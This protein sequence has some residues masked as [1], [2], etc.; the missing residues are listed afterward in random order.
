MRRTWDR[1][2]ICFVRWP[3]CPFCNSAQRPI[4][5]RSIR[6]LD[7]T[8]SR[9][10]RCRGCSSDFLIVIEIAL[11]EDGNVVW[12]SDRIL[13]IGGSHY[14]QRIHSGRRVDR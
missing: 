8:T 2:P 9:R 3:V 13:R 5:L 1:A 12:P 6:E 4:I 10:C 14:E 11:P 7:D